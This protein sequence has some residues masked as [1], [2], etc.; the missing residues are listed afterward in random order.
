MGI[1]AGYTYILPTFQEFDAVQ[2][3]L[4]SS[5]RNILKYRFQHTFKL[6]TEIQFGKFTPGVSFR[7]FSF[8]EA[9]DEAFNKFLPGIESFRNSNDG[10]T[11][12]LD[13]RVIYSFTDKSSFSLVV[14]NLTNAEYSLRPALMDAPRNFTLKFSHQF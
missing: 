7:Y 12:I 14:K 2:E 10:P 1:L 4:S 8:M 13:A 9:I 3:V 6:D 11:M 5:S